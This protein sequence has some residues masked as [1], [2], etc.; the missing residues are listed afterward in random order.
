MR[1]ARTKYPARALPLAVPDRHRL[2]EAN[3]P[4]AQEYAGHV[5]IPGL[6]HPVNGPE[7]IN[8]GRYLDVGELEEPIDALEA[9]C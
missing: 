9:P 8:E 3:D 7:L 1:F 2:V 6:D 4:C 5:V